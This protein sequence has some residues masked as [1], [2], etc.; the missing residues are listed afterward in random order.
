MEPDVA[1]VGIEGLPRPRTAAGTD[2]LTRD[3]PQVDGRHDLEARAGMLRETLEVA[4][5]SMVTHLAVS[6]VL[7]YIFWGHA[8]EAYLIG[9]NAAMCA[10]VSASMGL[11]RWAMRRIHGG[12]PEQAVRRGFLAAKAV[13]LAIGLLWSTMPVM[14][15]PGMEGGYQ[16][17]AVA[18]TAGLISDAYVVGPILDVS[19]LLVVPIVI[20]GFVGLSQCLPPFGLYTSL[21]LVVYALFV[22]LS[23][24]RMSVL[25]FRRLLDGVIV[26]EQGTTI[27]MLLNDFEESATDWLWETDASGGLRHAPPR[28][29][30][31]IGVEAKYLRGSRLEDLLGAHG[32]GAEGAN[33]VEAVLACMARAEPFHG[34]VV[35]LQTRQGTRWWSL[36]GKPSFEPD[37]TFAGYRGV[38]ADITRD[39]EAEARISYLA[40]HD[41]LTGLPN[42]SSF[43]MAV[44]DACLAA[45][46]GG[47]RTALLYVDLDGFKAVNDGH[48]HSIGDKL[49]CAV[50]DRLAGL[51][52]G[53]GRAFRLGGDEFSVLHESRAPHSAETLANEIVLQI[54]RPYAIDGLSVVVGTSLG[55]AHAPDDAHDTATL[56]SRADLALYDAKASGKGR[57][58]GFDPDLENKAT[59]RQRL[60]VEMRAALARDGIE[61]H[62][63]PLVDLLS[64]RVVGVEALLRWHRPSEGW[65]SPAEIIPIAE[66][67]GFI[68]DIGRWALRRACTD[69]LSW[70]GLTV[71]VNISSNHFRSCGF[72]AEVEAILEE[73]GLEPSRLEIEITES[74]VLDGGVDV[75]GNMTRLRSKGIRLSLDDFGTGYSSL[76]YLSNFRFDKLKIDRSFV[77][78]L[79]MRRDT[80]AIFD[81]INGLA[82]ALDM[83]VTVEGIEEPEQIEIL[84]ERFNG[85][86]QGYF[87]SKP[88]PAAQIGKCIAEIEDARSGRVNLATADVTGSADAILPLPVGRPCAA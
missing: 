75:T 67:T 55:I 49:L 61:L 53:R 1:P 32:C 8:P 69:V 14:L 57:W 68:I 37:G 86:V 25:S 87:Y 81:A 77:R 35:R 41:A 10:V 66:S 15:L 30:T 79:H 16:F 78:E 60:D 51:C 4:N 17:V 82:T 83:S 38:G 48:G 58:R 22:L 85:S 70:P 20:G 72:C 64:R 23:S 34:S 40:S 45:R 80:L 63:Q 27:G 28:M 71:A 65:I 43:Q 26:R 46:A 11:T 2:P 33:G 29:E 56:L 31:A 21:L 54:G 42:R 84:R 47:T 50:A 76:S 18:T 13:A 44:E 73:T 36:N 9:L 62:Y 6:L 59:R 74:I 52:Q 3:G 7:G 12:I 19:L 5:Y 39:Q 24:R 88:R